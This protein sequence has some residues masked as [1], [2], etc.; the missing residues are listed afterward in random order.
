MTSASSIDLDAIDG[1]ASL[2]R[3]TTTSADDDDDDESTRSTTILTDRVD[4][5]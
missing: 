2:M 4:E 3:A 5:R 1:D